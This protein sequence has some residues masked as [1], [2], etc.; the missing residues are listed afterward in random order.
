MAFLSLLWWCA[1]LLTSGSD[2]V[3]KGV[4]DTPK[5]VN[6]GD[7]AVFIVDDAGLCGHLSF[8]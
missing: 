2:F 3:G 1:T 6:C 7:D 8:L 4:T 5:E